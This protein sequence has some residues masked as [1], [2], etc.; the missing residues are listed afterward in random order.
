MTH[1]K[2]RFTTYHELD[3]GMVYMGNHDTCKIVGIG[4]ISLKFKDGSIKLIR[5][6]R[7][8]PMLKRNLLS[9]GM[10]DAIDF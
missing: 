6:W 10:F 4:S 5:N 8:V 9:L 7:H 1:Q 2:G 3:G